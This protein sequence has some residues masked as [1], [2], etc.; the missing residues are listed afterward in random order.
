MTAEQM[1]FTFQIVTLV[2][3]C[4]N[5]LAAATAAY[6]FFT[7]DSKAKASG[8]AE[9]GN[10]YK[11]FATVILVGVLFLNAVGFLGSGA[12]F[13]LST[14]PDAEPTQTAPVP[15]QSQ[16]DQPGDPKPSFEIPGELQVQ[17]T[18]IYANQAY[19]R[20]DISYFDDAHTTG[21]VY[22]NFSDALPENMIIGPAWDNNPLHERIAFTSSDGVA[23]PSIYRDAC[24][25]AE[26]IR[27]GYFGSTD[28]NVYYPD[29][30]GRYLPMNKVPDCKKVPNYVP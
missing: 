6:L 24:Y 19:I 22:I 28:F 16:P 5:M 17:G 14:T 23:W 13:A 1:T 8:K 30:N 7:G 21:D 25:F 15:D 4:I 26:D 3:T 20:V 10:G 29:G 9:D 12:S 11:T 18:T 27:L 2:L